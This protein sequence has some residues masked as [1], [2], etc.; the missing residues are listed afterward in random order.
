MRGCSSERTTIWEVIFEHRLF[1]IHL[2]RN[3]YSHAKHAWVCSATNVDLGGEFGAIWSSLGNA[4]LSNAKLSDA[5][6]SNAKPSNAKLS[7]A[8]LSNAKLSNAKLSNAKR[9]NA[10]QR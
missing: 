4:E 2:Q 10:K 3:V 9:S 8:E 6:L 1:V 5:E 7:D